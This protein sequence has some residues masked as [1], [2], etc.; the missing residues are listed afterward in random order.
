MENQ[1]DKDGLPCV[2]EGN[3]QLD[4]KG[5]PEESYLEKMNQRDLDKLLK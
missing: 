1:L 4:S 5:L 2:Q 3:N